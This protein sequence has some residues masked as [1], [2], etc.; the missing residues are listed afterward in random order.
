MHRRRFTETSEERGFALVLALA[1][2]SFLTLLILSLLALV[3]VESNL[4][5]DRAED[6]L[7]RRYAYLGAMLALGELQEQLGPDQRISARA[8]I[9]DEDP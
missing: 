3:G 7:A 1:L 9:L 8:E 6:T 4:A 2:L 5:R